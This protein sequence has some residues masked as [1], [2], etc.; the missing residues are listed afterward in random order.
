MAEVLKELDRLAD[1]IRQHQFDARN[2]VWEIAQKLTEARSLFPETKP[3]IGNMSWSDWTQAEVGL[4]GDSATRMIRTWEKFSPSPE[5]EKIPFTT[6]IE[7]VSPNTPESLI[8]E[9]LAEADNPPSKR[10][11]QARKKG[12]L[13]SPREARQQAI[14]SGEYVQASDG[15]LV[16]PITDAK[17]D[18]I[19]ERRTLVYEFR[20]AVEHLADMVVTPK[21]WLNRAA[22]HQTY[23]LDD[24]GDVARAKD[25]LEAFIE[26]F[27]SRGE[28]IVEIE[29]G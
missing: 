26:E 14:A 15:T 13:P 18:E 17:Q 22:S 1:E 20:D 29:N 27:N 3:M 16:A 4:N 10:E 25:Y 28:Q 24:I 6:L 5:A 8:K 9:V 7:L 23:T 12:V 19:N 11:V 2:S 21:E